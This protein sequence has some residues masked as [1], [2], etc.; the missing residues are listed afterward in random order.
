MYGADGATSNRS[1]EQLP[2]TLPGR[3]P[4]SFRLAGRTPCCAFSLSSSLYRGGDSRVRT[5]WMASR[6]YRDAGG[7]SRLSFWFG[8]QTPF[9]YE[10]MWTDGVTSKSVMQDR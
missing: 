6:F 1:A 7:M 10:S 8:S 5:V 3:N 9:A 4:P 2:P